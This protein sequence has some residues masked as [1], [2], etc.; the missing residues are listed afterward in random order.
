[1]ELELQTQEGLIKMKKFYFLF[2]VLFSLLF[3][4][5]DANADLGFGQDVTFDNE[6]GGES[7]KFMVDKI[8]EMAKNVNEATSK[9]MKIGD[10]LWCSSLH[11][12]AADWSITIGGATIFEFRVIHLGLWFSAAILLALGFMIS[13]VASFY[14]FDIAFNLGISIILLPLAIA[15]WPFGWTRSKL[16]QV[17][18]SIAYYVGV[19]MFLPL[20]IAIANEIIFTVLAALFG[21]ETALMEAFKNDQSD[22]IEEKLS[23][24]TL[25]FLKVLL[26]Y[27]VAFKII[28]LMATEF[29]GHFFGESLAGNPI[30]E[31]IT[32][33]IAEL[34]KR[35]VD[36]LAKY[37]KDV[38]KH[39]AG[40][41]IKKAGKKDGNFL[42]RA[43]H[44]FGS[45]VGKTK[46]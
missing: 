9:M 42:Q 27:V 26:S 17:V 20:G 21:N 32:Q 4:T 6:M 41:L 34:K 15:L 2:T 44:R 18:E 35:S 45:N 38:A 14:M 37:G 43:V 22:L 13:V 8:S 25:G 33:A 36:K 19:F 40:N 16:K 31:R 30:N 46:R 1:M 12:K 11:G 10:M 3:T 23:L 39:Q 5:I 7:L 24:F 28:P 29:C